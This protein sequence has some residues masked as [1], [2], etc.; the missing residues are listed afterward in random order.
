MS[1]LVHENAVWNQQ[2]IDHM[3]NYLWENASEVG[4]GEN[5]KDSVYQ[6][7]MTYIIPYHKSGPVKSAK[8]V[9]NK[10]KTVSTSSTG[11]WLLTFN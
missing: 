6:A 11:H 9:K 4:D 1:E 5:F 7:T 3:M 8:H 10:Y 2:E